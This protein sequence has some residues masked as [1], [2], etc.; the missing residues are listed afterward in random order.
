MTAELDEYKKRFLAINAATRL[1]KGSSAVGFGGMPAGNGMSDVNF[2]F[3]F[4]RFGSL[5]GPAPAT[6]DFYAKSVSSPVSP[7]NQGGGSESSATSQQRSSESPATLRNSDSPSAA[8]WKPPS[9]SCST[10]SDGRR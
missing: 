1:S 2:E 8:T 4:P 7:Y 9:A 10:V 5:P 6:G 3:E